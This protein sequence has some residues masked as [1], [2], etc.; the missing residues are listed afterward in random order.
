MDNVCHTLVGAALGE[1]GLKQRTRFG[2]L[3]L[4]IAANV[5]D[6]D[7]LVFATD[8]PAVAFRRGW[9]HG[10]VGQA[11]LPLALTAVIVGAGRLRSR[12]REPQAPVNVS[13]L[14]ALSYIGFYSHLFLDYLNNYGVRLLSPI[15]WRWFYG[16]AV[17][18]VDPWLW[19]A[20]GA[21]VWLARRSGR[22]VPAIG[23]LL[24]ASAYTVLMLAS[25]QAAR[26]VVFESWRSL[27]DAS[28]RALMVG[29]VPVVPFVRQVIIDG[30]D[31]YEVGQFSWLTGRLE[32]DSR[33]VPKRDD[34][35]EIAAARGA[36]NVR[37]FLSW[38]RFPYWE[39]EPV[40]TGI[41]VT[42]KDMRFGDRFA[43]STIVPGGRQERGSR[44]EEVGGRR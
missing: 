7:V 4:M 3:T 26:D 6:L 32:L 17:F 39:L 19:A 15:D 40:D 34:R 12:P 18:I 31:H 13:W 1:S 33:T 25:A 10:V 41:R 43:A 16:D 42:V 30:G 36:P 24:F 21:G 8:T 11:L 14:L 22:P 29:P 27:R 2:N 9:T 28:P 20:L 35:D 44:R 38:S 23:S 37:S 5:A